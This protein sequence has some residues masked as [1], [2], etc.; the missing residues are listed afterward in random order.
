[1]LSAAAVLCGAAEIATLGHTPG[2]SPLWLY[3][4]YP[5]AGLVYVAAGVVAWWRRPSNRLGTIMVFAG[6]TILVVNVGVFNVPT[7]SA[8]GVVLA[9]LPLAVVVHLVL[10]FPSGRLRSSVARWTVA[11]GYVACLVFEIPLYLFDPAASNGGMLAVASR[12]NL[13]LAGEWAQRALGIAVVSV[14]CAILGQRF[15]R[16]TPRQRLVLGPLYLYGMFTVLF[17]PLTPDVI[18]PLF[19]LS[20]TVAVATQVILLMGVP[21]AFAAGLLLGGFARTGE[22]AELGSW[23]GATALSRDSLTQ[24][25]AR[26]LGDDSVEVAYWVEERLL[27]VDARGEP[28]YLP[29]VPGRGQVEIDLDGRRIGAV[30]YDAVLIDDPALVRAAGRVVAIAMDH[31]RLTAELLASREELR[32]S[33][34]R[35]VEAADR[36]RR[37]IAQNLHDSLQMKLVLLA[38]KA[39]SLAGLPGASSTIADAAA[40]L[41]SDIDSAAAE[42]RELV[43]DVMPAPLIERGLGAAAQD[44]VD[45]LP[46]PTR[47]SLGVNG[48]VPEPVSSAAYFILAEALANAIKHAHATRLAVDLAEHDH[49]LRLEV[50]DD[51]IG[52]VVAG[53]GLGMRSIA[54]RVDVLGGSVHIHSPGGA[55]TQVVVELPCES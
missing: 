41:R 46:L 42:L 13:F 25:L 4:L 48:T 19:A 40:A 1:M 55:G 2:V 28:L 47:L 30:L 45:R 16:A 38:L 50:T 36:E 52:G 54:D 3:D 51:G 32:R 18:V 11:S 15:L 33:R 53:V 23:L 17:I 9:T 26:A 5:A 20:P 49:S 34:A 24:A 14:A 21:V 37:R 39:Q 22:I 8:V 43:H 31:D 12:P 27:Y 44:L 10:A 35:L 7:L 6:L 29:L